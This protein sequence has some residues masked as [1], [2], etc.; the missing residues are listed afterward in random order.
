[1]SKMPKQLFVEV[2]NDTGLT[3]WHRGYPELDIFP[4]VDEVP[5]RIAVYKLEFETVYTKRTR[6]QIVETPI[7]T[8]EEE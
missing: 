7:P 2:T 1:M 6:T 5:T 8:A 4:F 3:I